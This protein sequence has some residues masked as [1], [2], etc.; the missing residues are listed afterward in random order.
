M[1]FIGAC[2]IAVRTV[3]PF[4]QDKFT[5]SPVI[6]I[7]EDG[8][9]V[10]PILSGHVGKANILAEEIAGKLEAQAVITTATDVNGLFAVDVFAVNNGLEIV[11]R[12]G[13]RKVSSK[14]LEQRCATVAWTE[15]I[16]VDEKS[17]PDHL[18]RTSPDNADILISGT[19][20][21]FSSN[22][23]IL[24]PKAY[25]LGIGCK[26]DT[27]AENIRSACEKALDGSG[28][29]MNEIYAAA[30]I[31]L[32]A[33]E[34]GILRF[35]AVHGIPFYTYSAETLRD[36]EGSFT[37]SDFVERMTGVDNVSERAAVCHAGPGAQLIIKKQAF[38]GVTVAVAK[39]KVMISRWGR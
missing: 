10:I 5:D 32:K 4:V 18:I 15:D 16:F 33:R 13:I 34:S 35:T 12:D 26:K 39:R 21:S 3:A 19:G 1:I 29:T 14:L 36:T 27:P 28:I 8:K 17:L 22:L 2:G 7:D 31:D 23:I 37:H 30:S 9:F 24:R 6:V 20:E 25:V 38:N 11:N